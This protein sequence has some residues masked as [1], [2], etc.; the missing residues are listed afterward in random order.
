MFQDG[1]R[2]LEA[3]KTAEACDKLTESVATLPDS[4][5]MGALAECDTTL[6]RLS[7][8]WELWHELSSSAPSR[9]LR[10]DAAKNAA[11]LD[12]KLVRVTLHLVGE[13]PRDL[14]VTLDDKVVRSDE[15]TEHRVSPGAVTV[16]ASSPDI[17]RW[18]RTIDA[19]PG[20][21]IKIDIALV[22]S[23]RAVSRR[24]RARLLSL[25]LLGAGALG[26]GVGLVFGGLAY[27]DWHSA[28]DSC[29]GDV[30]HCKGA[31]YFTAQSQQSDAHD[32]AKV[33]SWSTGIGLGL[34]T[35]GVV[36][37]LAFRNSPAFESVAAWHPAPIADSQT[38]GLSLTRSLP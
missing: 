2:D 33:A 24:H 28:K 14:A 32:R 6:G 18:T 23:H 9:D 10:D 35:A 27:S 15:T 34:A 1:I 30:D 4:G 22:A 17:D 19:Q 25:S 13:A 16:V 8:A 37:F 5:A 20:T 36:V 31:G 12:Q 21:A 29:G 11:A 26:V 3:G 38:V 7:E